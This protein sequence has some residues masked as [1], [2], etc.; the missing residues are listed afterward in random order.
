MYGT[1]TL[2]GRPFQDRSIIRRFVTPR[3][4]TGRA[5][6]HR[7]DKSGRFRLLPVRSPLLGESRLISSP[8]GTE[9]FHFPG[10]SPSRYHLIRRPAL[11]ETV[12]QLSLG[13]VAQFGNPRI[14]ACLQL[15]EAYRSLP[16]PSSPSNAKAST[17]CP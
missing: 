3:F 10:L 1:S 11:Y 16:R 15:P 6:Q 8:P 12:A 9:M 4:Y 13:Q 17:M 2:Y 7:P 5:L 14:K